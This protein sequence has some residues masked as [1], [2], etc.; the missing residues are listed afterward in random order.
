[1]EESNRVSQDKWEEIKKHLNWYLFKYEAIWP[2]LP[3]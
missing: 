1:M 2:E 3:S